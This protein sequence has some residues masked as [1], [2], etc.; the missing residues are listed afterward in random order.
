M[1]EKFDDSFFTKGHPKEM[2]QRDRKRDADIAKVDDTVAKTKEIDEKELEVEVA[3]Y[4]ESH[5]DQDPAATKA[6]A[7]ARVESEVQ[8]KLK[9]I[10]EKSA[11]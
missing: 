3:K 10:N 8:E 6:E 4:Q 2:E 7:I 9:E 5:K 11:E 1:I